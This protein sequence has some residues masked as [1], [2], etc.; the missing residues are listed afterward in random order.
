MLV[1]FYKE[2]Y[3]TIRRYSETNIF[4]FN[5]IY[6]DFYDSWNYILQEPDFYNVALDLHLYDWQEPYTSESAEQHI[7]DAEGW[8][9]L[10]R[11]LSLTH[12]IIIGEWSYSTGLG[13]V[14][15]TI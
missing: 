14:Q 12:P 7:A 10:I 9:A 1:E 15:L 3:R 2:A 6:S 4:V 5:D 13:A 8:Q 11:R